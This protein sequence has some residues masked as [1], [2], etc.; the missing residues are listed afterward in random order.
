MRFD[1]TGLAVLVETVTARHLICCHTYER[2]TLSHAQSSPA[3][4]T[5]NPLYVSLHPCYG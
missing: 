4:A 5:Y 2:P 3:G 1:S